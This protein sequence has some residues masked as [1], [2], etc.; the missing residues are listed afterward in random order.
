M[1]SQ[2]RIVTDVP[3]LPPRPPTF[4]KGQTGR[5]AVIAGSRGMSGAAVLCG[6]GA[7]RSGA[8]LVRVITPEDVQPIVA[9]SEP[10]LM[11]VP[12]TEGEARIPGMNGKLLH[13]VYNWASAVALGPGLGIAELAMHNVPDILRECP[14]PLVIDTDGLNTLA[15]IDEG[16]ADASPQ[17]QHWWMI[18]RKA[19]TVI[20][21]HPGEMTRLRA[22][23]GLPAL[24]GDDDI[25]RLRLAHE[26]ADLAR[27]TVVLKGHRTIVST[28]DEAY[29]NTT[30]NAGMA[31]GGMGDVLTGLIATLLGIGLPPFDAARLGV[32]AHGAAADLLV[33]RIG[34]FGYLA[35]EVADAIPRVL[36]K[37]VREN[38]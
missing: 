12:V 24:S 21:P 1:N 37:R 35:R 32:W 22:A 38:S 8:G 29:I 33:D 14:A 9:A 4:H 13:S 19:L 34:P 3:S 36:A 27:C 5:V 18:R 11:T 20:T 23:A 7:L 2:P 31:T 16:W 30:G 6:L 10:C 26:Y 17:R 28:P 25:T 15:W